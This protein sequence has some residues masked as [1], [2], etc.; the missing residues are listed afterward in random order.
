MSAFELAGFH[1]LVAL[2]GSLIIALAATRG[3]W[4]L[5]ELWLRSRVDELW[6]AEQWGQDDEAMAVAEMK[7]GEFL[8]AGLVW[9]LLQ[10]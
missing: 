6:Q 2:S 8:H 5:E 4:P 3:A 1:D 10:E 9:S 7:K